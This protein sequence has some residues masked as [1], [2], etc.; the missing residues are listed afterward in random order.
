MAENVKKDEKS[1]KCTGADAKEE[2]NAAKFRIKNENK[3]ESK[4]AVT[5]KPVEVRRSMF[6]SESK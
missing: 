1:E 2:Q 5:E 3:G 6:E 4:S